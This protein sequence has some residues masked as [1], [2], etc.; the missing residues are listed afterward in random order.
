[1]KIKRLYIRDFGIFSNQEIA[2]V[3]PGLVVIGGLNRAGK[4]TLLQL[5]R[6]LGYGFP[7]S[8][9][10]PPPKVRYDVE[11]DVI[12][13]SGDLYNIRLLGHA[14]PEV[15][16]LKGDS[17]LTS[18]QLYNQLD[19][20][21]YQQL[22]TL[23]L[24]ELR[25]IPE[26]LV[27]NQT[28]KL[29]SILLGAGLSDLVKIPQIE[30]MLLKDA[31]KIG[32]KQ[33][34]AMVKEFKPYSQQIKAGILL[35][36]E[37][38]NQVD[39]YN[40]KKENL[41]E[42][43]RKISQYETEINELQAEITR[44][45]ILKNNYQEYTA[46]RQIEVKISGFEP[47][48]RSLELSQGIVEKAKLLRESFLNVVAEYDQQLDLVQSKNSTQ[49]IN[50]L[51]DR[52]LKHGDLLDV[53]LQ[54]LSGLQ[55]KIQNYF[56]L[57]K[58]NQNH[59]HEI[60]GEMKRLNEN[61]SD[62]FAQILQ[63]KA[64]QV[65]QDRLTQLVEEYRELQHKETIVAERVLEL[66]SDK[67]NIKNQLEKLKTVKP[68]ELMKKYFFTALIFII[69]GIGLLFV[70]NLLGALVGFVGVL[71]VGIY[72]FVQYEPNRENRSQKSSLELQLEKTIFE[73]DEK[74]SKQSGINSDKG[75]LNHELE[76]YRHILGLNT[77]VSLDL[78]KEHF[79]DIQRLQQQIFRLQKSEQKS[80]EDLHYISTELFEFVQLLNRLSGDS[81]EDYIKRDA[82]LAHNLIGQAEEIFARLL[83]A[84][85]ELELVRELVKRE[86]K[87]QNVAAK[88]ADLLPSEVLETELLEN[89]NRF[90][91]QGDEFLE[92]K[93]LDNERE[94]LQK[95]IL[96]S[97][98]TDRVKKA[99]EY[100]AP[101]KD[102]EGLLQIFEEFYQEYTSLEDVEKA[103]Y[104]SEASL[105]EFEG[106]IENLIEERQTLRDE[107]ERL[108]TTENLEKAQQQIDE[109]RANLRPLA[110]KYA[111]QK[112]AAFILSQIRQNFILK[113][114][115]TLLNNASSILGE[116]TA[117]EYQKILPV[118]SLIEADFKTVLN[119]GEIHNTAAILS[120]G[121][122]EQLFLAVRLSRILEIQPPLPVILDDTMVNFDQLHRERTVEVLCKLAETHQV[123]VLTCHPDLVQSIAERNFNP[124]F[125][126][127]DRG[128]FDLSTAIELVNSLSKN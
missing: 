63:I 39:Q 128:R 83:T 81:D 41:K 21:T 6:Y 78:I 86:Q 88:I 118:D 61:W 65:E 62:D 67:N 8:T 107:I 98:K 56:K 70:S 108:S 96:Q 46:A 111:V 15:N 34:S 9:T 16:C 72:Q 13:S 26:G 5:L 4:T 90:I 69:S 75:L 36:K 77:T 97:L 45:D 48:I 38:I 122:S 80:V 43:N 79:K 24:A 84:K 55:E 91:L 3:S 40:D 124:Q 37:A 60:I 29:Q 11:G 17:E 127:L 49:N 105:R 31:E 25:Q 32:G 119:S 7:K 33:G 54:K 126:R 23:S 110:E 112:A 73:L 123:F 27:K 22:F 102:D 100:I 93:K 52:F 74:Q 19:P 71:G 87:Y 47:V 121:S 125:W 117:G 103:Y 116:L 85:E 30:K 106:K 64:D 120:R 35:R 2:E 95:Q 114:R 101:F 99:M 44:L 14:E 20:M 68:S 51:K 42:V 89:L 50:E 92:F 10:F 28:E 18:Y 53:Y 66:K 12:H 94:N 76:G 82:T 58:D 104:D 59:K 115:D 1:M 57:S 113:A 109:A